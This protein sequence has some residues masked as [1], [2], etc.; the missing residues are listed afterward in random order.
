MC[1]GPSDTF[2]FKDA[3]RV[4]QVEVYLGPRIGTPLPRRVGTM[5]DSFLVA[6]NA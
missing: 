5:L 4:F 6:P 2:A 3:G 1:D